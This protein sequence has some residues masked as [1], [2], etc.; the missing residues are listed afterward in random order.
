MIVGTQVRLNCP[1]S[2]ISIGQELAGPLANEF[3]LL[4]LSRTKL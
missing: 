4:R 1:S 3:E 2:G